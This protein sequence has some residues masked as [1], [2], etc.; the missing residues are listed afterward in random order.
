MGGGGEGN[1]K[2]WGGVR[3]MGKG[4]REEGRVMSGVGVE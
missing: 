1:D 2:G 3:D 4:W